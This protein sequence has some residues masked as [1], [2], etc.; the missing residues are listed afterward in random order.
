MIWFFV[1]FLLGFGIGAS[2]VALGIALRVQKG[3][4]LRLVSGAVKWVK[5]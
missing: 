1:G 5:R 2:G 4:D 3:H